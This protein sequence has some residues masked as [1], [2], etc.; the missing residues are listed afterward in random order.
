[1]IKIRILAI[2][3]RGIIEE[4]TKDR[5]GDGGGGIFLAEILI[6]AIS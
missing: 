5:D 4:Q 3:W 6:S 1:M 2:T